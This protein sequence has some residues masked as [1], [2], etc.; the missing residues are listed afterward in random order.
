MSTSPIN[1]NNFMTITEAPRAPSTASHTLPQFASTTRHSNTSGADVGMRSRFFPAAAKNNVAERV[2][3]PL[4]TSFN[5]ESAFKS[6]HATTPNN[7]ARR[8]N[9][10]NSID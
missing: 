4:D 9:Y 3:N 7:N 6:S 1:V 5:G 2:V 8:I 10:R